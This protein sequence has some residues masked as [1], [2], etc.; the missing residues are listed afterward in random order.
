MIFSFKRGRVQLSDYQLSVLSRLAKRNRRVEY[1]GR[2]YNELVVL[3]SKGLA[4]HFMDDGLRVWEITG[5]GREVVKR[6][7]E[8]APIR[9]LVC[10]GCGME[11]SID[12]AERTRDGFECPSCGEPMEAVV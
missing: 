11:C 1:N 10:A 2:R 12:R 7:A 3:E 5:L 6:M 4:S 8:G 9:S